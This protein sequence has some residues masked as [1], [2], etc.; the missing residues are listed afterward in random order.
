MYLLV[1]LDQ[2]MV[3]CGS[4]KEERDGPLLICWWSWMD[5]CRIHLLSKLGLRECPYHSYC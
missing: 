5:P 1:V 4:V 3:H 2:D